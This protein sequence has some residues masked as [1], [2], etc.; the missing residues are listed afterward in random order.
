MDIPDATIKGHLDQEHKNKNSTQTNEVITER[1]NV[2]IPLIFDPTD[3]IYSDLPGQFTTKYSK[4]NQYI[5]VL[6]HYDSNAI[7]TEP[8]K[9]RTGS[10][11]F[12]EYAEL[13]NYLISR[14]M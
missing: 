4:G 12:R 2:V 13:S 9:N 3:K 7:L 8:M 5:F 11:I 6:Y 14:G 10:E 1:T